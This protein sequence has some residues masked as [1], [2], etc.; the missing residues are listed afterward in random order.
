MI[1]RFAQLLTDQQIA[2][3]HDTSPEVPAETG[4]LM[5]NEKARDRPHRH[6]RLPD[7]RTQIVGFPR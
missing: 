6:G 5:R 4:L 2:Q 7:P 1:A 3:V